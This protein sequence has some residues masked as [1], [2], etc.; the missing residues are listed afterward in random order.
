MAPL[1]W[2][3]ILIDPPRVKTTPL[4]TPSPSPDMDQRQK[5]VYRANTLAE[6]LPFALRSSNL[7]SVLDSKGALAP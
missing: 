4:P 2:E 1:K 7:E 5:I 6:F 3:R